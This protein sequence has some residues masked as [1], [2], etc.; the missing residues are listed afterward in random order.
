MGLRNHGISPH[1]LSIS[2]PLVSP[3]PCLPP[4]VSPSPLS[5]HSSSMSP[6]P[7]SISPLLSISPHS[8][9]ISPH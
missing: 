2:S 6:H 1:P 9:S 8:S 5:V 7:L 4:L 3:H